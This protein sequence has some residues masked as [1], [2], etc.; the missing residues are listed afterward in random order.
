M[1]ERKE[2]LAHLL[3]LEV[4]KLINSSRAEVDLASDILTYYGDH[5]PDLLE[6]R[7]LPLP[8]GTAVL[9]NEPLGVLFGVMP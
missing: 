6:E 5:G 4:G 9:V 3:T 8:E 1:R 2:E 7:P